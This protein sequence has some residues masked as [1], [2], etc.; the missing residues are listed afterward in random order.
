MSHKHFLPKQITRSCAL[1]ALAVLIALVPG[2][3][4]AIGSSQNPQGGSVGLEG[5]ISSPPPTQA[6]TISTPGNGQG[7]SSSPIKIAGLCKSGLL[8]KIF[9]NNVFVG[10]VV[11]SAG[12]YSLEVGLFSGTND[13]VAR[14]YDALDQSGPDS[15]LVSVT[16]NDGNFA[17]PGSQLTLTSQ[18]GRMG[19]QP[20]DELDWPIIL[21]GGAGPYAISADW[22]DSSPTTLYSETFAG[23]IHIKHT[24]TSAGVYN[25]I[26][27]ATDHNGSAA[28]LQVV[29][30]VNGKV[31][32]GTSGSTSNK[33]SSAGGSTKAPIPWILVLPTIPLLLFSFWLGSHNELY[34]I[35]KRLDQ[36]RETTKN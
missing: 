16:F 9:S 1:L 26:I 6:A 17:T 35:R 28:Y 8:V 27:K 2:R 15:N 21:S 3:V 23:V 14:V 31:T 4:L 29:A 34:V 33:G 22:G 19:V 25:V 36:A 13:L 11:C 20:H 7:F 32:S 30:V 12:S 10:S 5:T 24:Y 18:Y